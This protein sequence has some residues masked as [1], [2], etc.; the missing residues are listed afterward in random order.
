MHIDKNYS[1][2]GHA[3]LPRP[4]NVNPKSLFNQRGVSL[5]ELIAFLIIVGIA[6]G[7][8]FKAYNYSLLH[9][10]DPLIEMRALE[11]AQAKLDDI[12][13]LKYDENTPSGG[14]PACG[15]ATAGALVCTNNPDGNMNDVDD[16]NGAVD[17]PY[18]GYT[19]TVTVATAASEKLITV[20]VSAPQNWTITLAVVRAN[21]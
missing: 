13:A 11:L 19:R 9:S 7:A 21:F 8:L 3:G 2:V 16:Y 20:T 10:V 4:S 6:S 15:S 14:I 5:I 12:F 17:V 18:T 1:G